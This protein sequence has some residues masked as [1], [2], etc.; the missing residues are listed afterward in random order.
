MYFTVKVGFDVVARNQRNGEGGK[1]KNEK[2][3]QNWN[4]HFC[5][6]TKGKWGQV[7]KLKSETPLCSVM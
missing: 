7:E 2:S 6:P 1:I 3:W 4:S 5:E